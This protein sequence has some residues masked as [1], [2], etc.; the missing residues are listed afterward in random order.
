MF[1]RG[2]GT[3]MKIWAGLMVIWAGLMV[4]LM[5]SAPS[6]AA[7]DNDGHRLDLEW[8]GGGCRSAPNE[9][10]DDFDA[11]L[12]ISFSEAPLASEDRCGAE[13]PP[14]PSPAGSGGIV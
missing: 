2:L 9:G 13:G 14:S 11:P 1:M 7:V 5:A 12:T 3:M 10:Y 4:G 8:A 6:L